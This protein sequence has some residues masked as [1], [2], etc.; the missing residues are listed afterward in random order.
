MRILRTALAFVFFAT[1]A[2]AAPQLDVAKV[3]SKLTSRHAEWVAKDSWVN[4]LSKAEAQ[5]M[6]GYPGKVRFGKAVTVKPNYDLRTGSDSIDWRNKDG[7]NWVTPVLNQ[8]NC[9]SCV[10]YSTVGTLETQ[11]NISRAAPFLNMQYS[12][13]HL[14]AC[15]G[16]SCES[17]WYP[18]SAASFLQGT[19]VVDE[20]CM[21]STSKA[22]GQDV[23][24]T[25]QCSDSAARSQKVSSVN[26]PRNAD[27]VKAALKRGPLV[28]TLD[29]YADFMVYGSG[30]YKHSTGDYMGGHAVSIVGFDDSKRAWLIRNSWGS[31]WGD[32][33]FAWVSYDD[34]SGV[35]DST[36]G[37]EIP[38]IDGYVVPRNLHDND[39]LSGD[40][41]IQGY[42]SFA[43][44]SKLSFD[45]TGPN[46]IRGS[47]T[48][49]GASCSLSLSTRNMADG[50]YEGTLSATHDGKVSSSDKRFFYVVNQKPNATLTFSPKGFDASQPIKA[51][52]EFDI[53][54]DSAPVP[55]SSL[56][57][58]VKQGDKVIYTKGADL[59]LSKM[60]MGWR[61]IFVPNGSYTV[62]LI[63]HVAGFDTASNVLNVTVAN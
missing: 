15:G 6:M 26:T 20:A 24:C 9:G 21:P 42:S 44:T 19:G 55:L 48:C 56:T 18:D 43:N 37:F 2:L 46:A 30:V 38:A 28:T 53:S 13:D 17:G 8:G 57:L 41:S 63:G 1:T 49:E 25:A 10:A 14:F 47:A 52:V 58:V 59:V 36:W 61:T 60:T 40:I 33:G 31:D 50:R 62:Q 16:G 54:A 29:V 7:Q 5:R 11:M 12:A 4:Q 39:F 22:T 45:Y 3:Q 51:R 27:A 32:H 35:G 34:E 23:S